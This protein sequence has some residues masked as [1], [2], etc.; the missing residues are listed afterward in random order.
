MLAPPTAAAARV[1]HNAAPVRQVGLHQLR[2]SCLGTGFTFLMDSC[3]SNL[4]DWWTS[5]RGIRQANEVVGHARVE[6]VLQ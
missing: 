6:G 2:L 3:A 4:T 5:R 1:R